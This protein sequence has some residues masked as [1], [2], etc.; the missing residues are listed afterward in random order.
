M[1]VRSKQKVDATPDTRSGLGTAAREGHPCQAIGC[2]I[3]VPAKHLMC[4]KHWF[5]V[6]EPLREQLVAALNDWL[7]GKIT[8][9]P[10]TV[11]RLRAIIH[12][13]LLHGED[14]TALEAAL[15]QKEKLL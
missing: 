8:V 2:S 12:V 11:A 10:Y 9:R 7:G 1:Y 5:E 15:I 13:G 6:P 14:M 3:L 4:Q